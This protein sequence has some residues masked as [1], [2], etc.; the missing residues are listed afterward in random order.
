M[1][2]TA[3]E[4]AEETGDFRCSKCHQTTHVR[5]GERI[6]KCPHCGNDTFDTRRHEPGSR[7]G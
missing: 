5:K 4:Q 2:A 1:A 7:S 6:P 3:G